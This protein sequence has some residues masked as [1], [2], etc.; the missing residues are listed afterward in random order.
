MAWPA[1]R[2]RQSSVQWPLPVEALLVTTASDGV[3]TMPVLW[4]WYAP[5]RP[6]HDPPTGRGWDAAGEP[7]P[8]SFDAVGRPIDRLLERLARG[9]ADHPPGRNC[10]RGPGLGVA[11]DARPLP[12]D[13]PRAK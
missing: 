4:R 11:P 3:G 2:Y 9:E 7:W 13:L 6:A 8:G 1:I 5:P 12:M 10:R